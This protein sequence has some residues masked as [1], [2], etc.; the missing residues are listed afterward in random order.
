MRKKKG[1][2]QVHKM[3]ESET[4]SAGGLQEIKATLARVNLNLTL[5]P[6]GHVDAVAALCP[7]T[8]APAICHKHTVN[9]RA[10]AAVC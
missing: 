5:L 4:R 9:T 1:N 6:S 3:R 10:R 8:V 2:L 7:P